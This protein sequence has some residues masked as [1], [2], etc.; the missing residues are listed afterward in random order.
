MREVGRGERGRGS[1]G[2]MYCRSEG[3]REGVREGVREGGKEKG[4]KEGKE[5]HSE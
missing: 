5:G 3:G 1:E 4:R 2:E